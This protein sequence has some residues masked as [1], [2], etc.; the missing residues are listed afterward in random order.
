MEIGSPNNIEVLLHCHR[1]W[2]PHP[3]KDAPAV[4]E[5]LRMLEE[6]G[7]IEKIGGIYETTEK[8]KAW[9]MA[10]CNVKEPRFVWVDEKDN[11][12]K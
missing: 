7:A 2:E 12:L 1:C 6:A 3:R 4:I 8:G 9:V 5:A 10:L 11:I